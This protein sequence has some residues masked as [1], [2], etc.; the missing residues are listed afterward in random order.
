V[1]LVIAGHGPGRAALEAQAAGDAPSRV[2]FVGALSDVAPVYAAADAVVLASRT[3]GMPGVLIEAGLSERPVVAY[4]VGAVSEIVADG[5]T[6]LLVS[7]GDVTGLAAALRGVLE[8]PGAMG[9]VAR[10]RCLA[11]FEIGVVGEKWAAVV[12]EL[13]A[14]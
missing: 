8:D 2:R 9:A 7:S 1:H 11:R 12:G 14:S 3:E 5:E 13:A 6:G 10:Q 4:D